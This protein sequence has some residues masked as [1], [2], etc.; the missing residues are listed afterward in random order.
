[1]IFIL[2]RKTLCTVLTV[3]KL[4]ESQGGSIKRKILNQ[5]MKRSIRN[6]G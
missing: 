6:G 5:E 4:T 3:Y 2:K 1:M